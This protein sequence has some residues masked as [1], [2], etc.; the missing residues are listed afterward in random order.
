M[1]N[2]LEGIHTVSRKN[3]QIYNTS[4]LFGGTRTLLNR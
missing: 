3:Y 2:S 1:G 4:G